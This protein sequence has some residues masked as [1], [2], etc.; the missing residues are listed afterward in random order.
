MLTFAAN[1]LQIN[2]LLPQKKP[3]MLWDSKN[4]GHQSDDFYYIQT[5]FMWLV[6]WGKITCT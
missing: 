3:K 6:I 2:N 5:R 4:I 1:I